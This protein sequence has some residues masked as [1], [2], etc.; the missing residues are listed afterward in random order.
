M[1]HPHITPFLISLDMYHRMIEVNILSE[2]DPV[3]LIEGY[4]ITMSPKG[5]RHAACVSKLNDWF[6]PQLAG[7][8]QLRVQ[9]PIQIPELS[10]PEPDLV[11]VSPRE[12]FYA[13]AHPL[14]EDVLLIMEV[15]D[16]SL[17]M[18]REVKSTLYATARIAHYWILNLADQQ[19]EVFAH[20]V[21]GKYTESHM[22]AVGEKVG[23]PILQTEVLV[24]DW[25]V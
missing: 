19:L 3:E 16:S 11:L 4:I 1:T 12:D 24:Q 10:E 21:E 13:Y 14:P 22:Y 5:S 9:D 17:A 15:A 2:D 25:L 8:A 18:D 6:M 20:P 7:K 23:V